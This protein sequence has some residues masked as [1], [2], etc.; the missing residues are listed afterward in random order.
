MTVSLQLIALENE[1]A[2]NGEL[3]HSARATTGPDGRDSSGGARGVLVTPLP[4]RRPN[5]KRASCAL[6]E[7]R[8]EPNDRVKRRDQ[9]YSIL[10]CLEG[11]KSEQKIRQG[12][13]TS[14]AADTNDFAGDSLE[15][16]QPYRRYETPF[17][18]HSDGLLKQIEFEITRR[19]KAPVGHITSSAASNFGFR[20]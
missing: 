15:P 3:A 10:N 13:Y 18:R 2:L 12:E 8:Y 5:G 20:P 19:S 6:P 4:E 9:M 1:S 14:P 7:V 17:C 11:R 16:L